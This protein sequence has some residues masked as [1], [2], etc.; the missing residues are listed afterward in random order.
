MAIL[1]DVNEEVARL[2]SDERG[3]VSDGYHTFNELYEHRIILYLALCK[4]LFDSY[5]EYVTHFNKMKNPIWRSYAHSD[6]SVWDGWFLLG[7]ETEKGKQITYH[8]PTKY[9]DECGYA[10]TLEKAPEFDGHT[11]AEVLQRIKNLYS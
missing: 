8:L 4:C 5:T 9:W 6:G 3:E 10:D 2:T 11:S 1:R 7:I